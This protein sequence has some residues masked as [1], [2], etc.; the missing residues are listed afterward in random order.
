MIDKDTLDEIQEICRTKSYT[1]IGLLYPKHE[2]GQVCIYAR[3]IDS[4]GI[5]QDRLTKGL[6]YPKGAKRALARLE[7]YEHNFIECTPDILEVFGAC[8]ED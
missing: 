1:R 3:Y 7:T 8:F 2:F 4:K 5:Q 6:G